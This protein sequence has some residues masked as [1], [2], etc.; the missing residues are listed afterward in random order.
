MGNDKPKPPA[1]NPPKPN[2]VLKKGIN[3]GVNVNVNPPPPNYTPKPPT[4]PPK[5]KK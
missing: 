1:T 3:E 5:P 2:Q 4:A